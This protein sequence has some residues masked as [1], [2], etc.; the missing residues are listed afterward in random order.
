MGLLACFRHRLEGQYRCAAARGAP[1]DDMARVA[2]QSRIVL[3]APPT[4]AWPTGDKGAYLHALPAPARGNVS[5]R[6]SRFW[7]VFFYRLVLL[8]PAFFFGPSTV[9][10]MGPMH[11]HDP[12]ADARGYDT[13]QGVWVKPP[14]HDRGCPNNDPVST[15][16]GEPRANGHLGASRGTHRSGSARTTKNMKL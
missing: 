16:A 4:A 12:S 10:S 9:F 1:P 3:I 14:R 8:A 2:D 13:E 6:F 5:C 7:V 11:G 15:R